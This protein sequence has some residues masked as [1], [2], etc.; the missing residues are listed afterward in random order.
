MSDP[1]I[2]IPG[3]T[4]KQGCGISEGKFEENYQR[5]INTLLVAPEDM[6]RLGLSDGDKVRVTNE[7]GQIEVAV[8]AAKPDELPAGMLFIAYGDLS[9][10]LMGADTHGSGMPTSKGLDVYLEKI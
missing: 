5:E 4:S 1:F 7:T 2:L 8:A 9:S 10:R 6:E 3:R